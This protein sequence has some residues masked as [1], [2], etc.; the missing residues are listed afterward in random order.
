MSLQEKKPRYNIV[1]S[2]CMKLKMTIKYCIYG[3]CVMFI[4]IRG[5]DLRFC[6]TSLN[7]NNTE[8]RREE[9]RDGGEEEGDDVY[10]ESR[11]VHLSN[12]QTTYPENLH[13][14]TLIN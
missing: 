10:E 4:I 14:S 1:N 13:S 9:G 5:L 7:D 6:S 3:S 11:S 8:E 2:Y 12:L